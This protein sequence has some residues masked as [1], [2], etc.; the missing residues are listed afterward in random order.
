LAILVAGWPTSAI[1]RS[2]SI[3]SAVKRFILDPSDRARF[4]PGADHPA[5]PCWRRSRNTDADPGPRLALAM[6]WVEPRS[7]FANLAPTSSSWC[8]RL[9]G[10]QSSLRTPPAE[11]APRRR[12]GA[13][14]VGRR[15]GHD[16]LPRHRRPKPGP[17]Q[18]NSRG[19]GSKPMPH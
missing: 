6:G 4:Y 17:G 5:R 16:A 11:P 14:E 15:A 7:S 18:G 10:D 13:I 8:W 19:I 1:R 2:V 9:G 12:H 3:S